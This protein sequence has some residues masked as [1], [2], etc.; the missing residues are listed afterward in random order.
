[1]KE[2]WKQLTD[3]ELIARIRQ[4]QDEEDALYATDVL[5]ERYK[6]MVRGK[7][8]SYFLIGA[9][10]DDVIQEGMIG[11]YKAVMDYR[12]DK[13]ASFRSFA[14]LCVTRQIASAVR[15]S[16]RRKHWPLN[17]YISLDRPVNDEEGKETMM[18]DLLPDVDGKTPEEILM[19]EDELKRMQSEVER[20]FSSLEKDVLQ[21]FVK[22][23]DYNQIAQKLGKKPKSIDNALQRVKHKISSIMQ[24]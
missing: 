6:E 15:L 8:R 1:M 3:E 7:A 16:L 4:K 13:A 21:L 23:M 24:S 18:M 17:H 10:R 19:G 14:E 12:P 20:S 9:D 5:M 22:G 11:L 2:N